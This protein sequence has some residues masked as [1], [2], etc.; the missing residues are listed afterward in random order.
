[1]AQILIRN[2]KP[3]LMRRLQRRAKANGR[4]LQDEV[5]NILEQ[6]AID[7]GPKLSRK[8][9]LAMIDRIRMSFKGRVFSDSTK[10]IREDRDSR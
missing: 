4:S 3:D 7:W 8:K 5:R 10:M 2:I 6:A 1:L 9:A